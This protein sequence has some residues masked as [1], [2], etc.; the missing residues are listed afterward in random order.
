MSFLEYHHL[1]AFTENKNIKNLFRLSNVESEYRIICELW[2]H[3]QIKLP[4][5]EDVESIQMSEDK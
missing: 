1:K 4:R 2:N 3:N 5:T